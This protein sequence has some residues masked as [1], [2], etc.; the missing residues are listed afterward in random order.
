ML[1]DHRLS[2]NPLGLVLCD[3]LNVIVMITPSP[4]L[5]NRERIAEALLAHVPMADESVAT[6]EVTRRVLST[7][8]EQ[9]GAFE[10]SRRQGY[11]PSPFREKVS[12]LV[13]ILLPFFES[14]RSKYFVGLRR[15]GV[16]KAFETINVFGEPTLVIAI[17][18]GM[19]NISGM[20]EDANLVAR[21]GRQVI[22]V[23]LDECHSISNLTRF[24]NEDVQIVVCRTD[25]LWSS[26][27]EAILALGRTRLKQSAVNQIA[28]KAKR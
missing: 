15:Q 27:G 21:V 9:I 14:S 1:E 20:L 11:E 8:V 2:A 25:A 24:A 7:V 28:T 19:R 6:S 12:A 23:F 3:Q 4:G 16:F 5:A 10:K 18:N 26:L 22:V 17:S 13:E